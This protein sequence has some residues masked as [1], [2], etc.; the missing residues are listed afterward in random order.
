[1]EV[2]KVMTKDAV[3]VLDQTL[4]VDALRQMQAHGRAISVLPVISDTGEVL[5]MIRNTDILA[6]GI[7]IS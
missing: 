3:C 7:F 1:M 6:G 2:D 4:A 5:G